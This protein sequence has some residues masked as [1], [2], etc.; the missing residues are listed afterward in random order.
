MERANQL[1]EQGNAQ[2]KSGNFVKA[3]ELYTQA[4]NTHPNVVYYSNRAACYFSLKKYKETIADCEKAI[5][6]DPTFI[7]VYFRSASAYIKLGYLKEAQQKLDQGLAVDPHER[8]LQT[9]KDTVM[10]LISYKNSLDHHIGAAEFQDAS[11]KLDYL[12]EKCEMAYEFYRKKVEVLCCLGDTDKASAFLREK[13]Y[14]LKNYNESLYYYLQAMVARYKNSFEESK[15]LLTNGIRMDPDNDL[16]KSSLKLVRK[17]EEAKQRADGLFKQGKH[18]EA[19]SAYEE[20]LKL[21]PYNKIYNAVILSNQASCYIVLKDN[22]TALKLLKKA[23]EYNP[24]Y[25][26]AFFKKSEVESALGDY[27]SAEQSIRRAKTLD[28]SMNVH[29]K[30][31]SYSQMAKKAKNK[32]LYKILEVD[33]KASAADIKKAYRKLAMKYHPDKNQGSA[34]EREI[35]EKKFKDISEA[36]NILSDEKKRRQYDMGGYEATGSTQDFA[37]HHAGF[38][39][40]FGEGGHPIFQMFFGPGSSNSFNFRSQAGGRRQP[41]MNSFFTQQGASGFEN[42]GFKDFRF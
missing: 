21:E 35:A 13:E 22:A 39:D 36:Y 11:R 15:R 23:C 14:T 29:A 8:S 3:I 2:F 10:L 26:K 6:L 7:K 17:I 37:Q 25:A 27:E 38:E 40:M 30:L 42:F 9:E 19:I 1:K 31:K 4:I 41:N 20:I 16:L 24:N 18:R 33:K 12:I 34:E 28:P 32:D 5:E